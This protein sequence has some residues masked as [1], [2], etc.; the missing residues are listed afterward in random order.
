MVHCGSPN[1]NKFPIWVAQQNVWERTSDLDYCDEDGGDKSFY[2]FSR[3]TIDDNRRV[4]ILK[5]EF[6]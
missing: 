4:E 2:T 6:S 5:L 3:D 1:F